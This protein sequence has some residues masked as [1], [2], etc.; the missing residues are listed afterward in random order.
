MVIFVPSPL[1]R[2]MTF[3]LW[4]N[5]MRSIIIISTY[6]RSC[7]RAPPSFA[8]FVIVVMI[9]NLLGSLAKNGFDMF[10][11][12]ARPFLRFPGVSLTFGSKV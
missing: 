5:G 6:T 7:Y 1:Y 9:T 11:G 8:I 12:W 4:L 10:L 3:S 2:V